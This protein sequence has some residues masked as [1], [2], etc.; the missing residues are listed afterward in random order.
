MG[1]PSKTLTEGSFRQKHSSREEKVQITF[2]MTSSVWSKEG[3][4][5]SEPAL[6]GQG[7][8]KESLVGLEGS[9]LKDLTQRNTS[10]DLHF[11]SIS[12]MAK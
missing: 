10:A 1:T 4:T 6:V 3:F 11:R 5:S 9:L 8:T 7:H 12:V 2:R